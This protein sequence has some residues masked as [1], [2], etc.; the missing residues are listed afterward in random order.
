MVGVVV[1][2]D[3]GGVVVGAAV[4][5]VVVGGG[6]GARVVGVTAGA[7]VLDPEPVVVGGGA[8]DVDVVGAAVVGVV[9][10]VR[11]AALE[12][13][14]PLFMAANQTLP[15]FCPFA[16]PFFLSPSKRYSGILWYATCQRPFPTLITAKP[17]TPFGPDTWA[18]FDAMSGGQIFAQA[19]VHDDVPGVSSVKR[20]S[21]SPDAV[22][23]TVPTPVTL[24]VETLTVLCVVDVALAGPAGTANTRAMAAVAPTMPPAERVPATARRHTR[25]VLPAG[26]LLASPPPGTVSLRPLPPPIAISTVPSC[27]RA[28]LFVRSS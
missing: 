13:G 5:G 24:A 8:G 21:V 28:A 26:D 3:V 18:P 2:G 16:C 4:G 27:V 9:D 15:T 12:A 20:Y 1:G 25:R 22:V 19:P 14:M 23:S 11:G 10:A 6:A 17:F 7:G